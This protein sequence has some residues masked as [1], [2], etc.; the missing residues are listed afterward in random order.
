VRAYP[1]VL[2]L[3]AS[4]GVS[5]LVPAV[6][7]FNLSVLC[8]ITHTAA[9]HG[10]HMRAAMLLVRVGCP[11][12]LVAVLLARASERGYPAVLAATTGVFAIA[13]L[14]TAIDRASYTKITYYDSVL[15]KPAPPT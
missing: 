3:L 10:S 7:N 15:R 2:S 1:V 13:L 14:L 4:S 5:L 11:I 12:W 9:A 6:L 8:N